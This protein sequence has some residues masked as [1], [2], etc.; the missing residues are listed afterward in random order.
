MNKNKILAVINKTKTPDQYI[1]NQLIND[2]NFAIANNKDYL[3]EINE[4]KF[5]IYFH[6]DNNIIDVDDFK[7]IIVYPGLGLSGLVL[8]SE[9]AKQQNTNLLNKNFLLS[10]NIRLIGSKI[11]QHLFFKE[12]NIPFLNIINNFDAPE[13]NNYI[14][15]IDYGSL[16]LGIC[17]PKDLEA[18]PYK[19][20]MNKNNTLLEKYITNKKDYRVIVINKKSLGAVYKEN[21]N[22]KIVNFYSGAVFS[23][24]DF[25][26]IEQI[27]EKICHLLNLD[28]CGIDFIF[29]EDTKKIYVLEINFFAKYEGFELVYGQGL[30]LNKIKEYFNDSTND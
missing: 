16:G 15:K 18:S 8:L 27:A 20:I 29:D 12:N 22:N 21:Q 3:F 9:K 23:K 4:D 5:K 30:I 2:D 26:E 17:L 14:F 19:K 24:V 13:I 11:N 6:V 28:Y 10:K 7:N 1:L 25:P